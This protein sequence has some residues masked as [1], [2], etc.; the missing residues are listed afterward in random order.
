M[1][2]FF[3]IYIPCNR[4][5][6]KSNTKYFLGGFFKDINILIVM[7]NHNFYVTFV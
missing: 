4:F 1:S 2:Y 7:I 3:E 6:Q 5:Y